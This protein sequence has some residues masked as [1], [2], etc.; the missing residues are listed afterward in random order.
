VRVWLGVCG[1]HAAV[2]VRV[3]GGQV[4]LE[5]LRLVHTPLLSTSPC[6]ALPLVLVACTDSETKVS[7]SSSAPVSATGGAGSQWLDHTCRVRCR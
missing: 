3:L 2:W 6:S 7:H 4:K 5:I 1:A